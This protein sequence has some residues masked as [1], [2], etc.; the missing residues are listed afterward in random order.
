MEDGAGE[1]KGGQIRRMSDG[2]GSERG[3]GEEKAENT[4]HTERGRRRG[5]DWAGEDD[6][7]GRGEHRRRTDREE[8]TKMRSSL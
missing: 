1:R 8:E 3:A 2:S 7:R 5:G 4:G 6:V